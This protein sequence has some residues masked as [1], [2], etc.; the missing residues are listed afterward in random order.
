MPVVRYHE[1]LHAVGPSWKDAAA[2]HSGTVT[3]TFHNILALVGV[4]RWKEHDTRSI[5]DSPAAKDQTLAL[6]LT[7]TNNNN[8]HNNNNKILELVDLEQGGARSNS[9]DRSCAICTE[10]FVK[11]ESVR[12][13]LCGHIYHQACVD[14]WLVEFSATCP[15]W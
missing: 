13:L 3:S 10:A 7:H 12:K 14:R 6:E 15:V 1:G 11:D 9:P 2:A 4:R 5:R 8:N